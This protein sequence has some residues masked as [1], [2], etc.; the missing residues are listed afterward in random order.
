MYVIKKNIPYCFQMTNNQYLGQIFCRQ[1]LKNVM[2]SLSLYIMR[3]TH[4]EFGN[5]ASINRNW[6]PLWSHCT[7]WQS[8]ITGPKVWAFR[9]GSDSGIRI[10]NRLGTSQS[11]QLNTPDCFPLPDVEP[12]PPLPPPF[13]VGVLPPD[14]RF[15]LEDIICGWLS[16]SFEQNRACVGRI[17]MAM[18]KLS[19]RTSRNK[20]QAPIADDPPIA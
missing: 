19:P 9:R 6:M 3:M 18:R 5:D 4:Y 12:S 13:F 20:W 1:V 11:C 17:G 14:P 16:W 2:K 7:S 8:W 10:L 15:S